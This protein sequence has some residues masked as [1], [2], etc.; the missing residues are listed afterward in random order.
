MTREK[1]APTRP[2]VEV[3]K[4]FH[5][6][7]VP[8]DRHLLGT[9]TILITLVESTVSLSLYDHRGEREL[10]RSLD[11]TSF[12]VIAVGS[13]GAVALMLLGAAGRL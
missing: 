8:L 12:V 4:A 6:H 3:A 9:V 10:W 13:A 7:H 5:I 1:P 11:R 2:A